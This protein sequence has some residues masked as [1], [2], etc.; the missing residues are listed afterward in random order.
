[1][2][3][4]AQAER[5]AE[6]VLR[7]PLAAQSQRTQ[8]IARKASARRKR[9]FI[10]LTGGYAAGLLIGTALDAS[11][12]AFSCAGAGLGLFLGVLS[13]FRSRSIQ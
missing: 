2:L 12:F 9:V 5:A 11:V 7:A 4:K 13:A 6:A 10:G 1:M 3:S 8:A